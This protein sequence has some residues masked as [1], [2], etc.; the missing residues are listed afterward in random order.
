MRYLKNKLF[1]SNMVKYLFKPD[2]NPELFSHPPKQE[3]GENDMSLDSTRP[4]QWIKSQI[5]QD[6]YR[7]MKKCQS[8][9]SGKSRCLDQFGMLTQP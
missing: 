6:S 2:L 3:K 1:S 4:C 5:I 9:T 7:M 8:K